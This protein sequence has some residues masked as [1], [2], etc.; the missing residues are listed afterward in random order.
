LVSTL[1]VRRRLLLFQLFTDYLVAQRQ[2]L[3]AYPRGTG[4][5]HRRDPVAGLRAEAALPCP[6]LAPHR[7]DPGDR[8]ANHL[9]GCSK[10]RVHVAQATVADVRTWPGNQLLDL[11]LALS[12]ERARQMVPS[13]GHSPTVLRQDRCATI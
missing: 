9:A 7:L 10:Y 5:C 6:G 1:G 3:V 12:T 4:R 11:L 8:R 2:A 13:V